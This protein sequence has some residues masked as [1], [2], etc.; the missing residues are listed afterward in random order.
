Q[1]AINLPSSTTNRSLFMTGAQGLVDQMDRLSGIVV[2]QN[3]I[4]NEQ[5]DIFSEEANN[6]VQKISELNKQVA[7]KSA[8]NLNNVDHSVLNE[9]DQAIKELAELVDIETLDGENGEKLV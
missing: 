3:S 1:S 5:L 6:L 8:L 4:V 7:S 2:D 9:R